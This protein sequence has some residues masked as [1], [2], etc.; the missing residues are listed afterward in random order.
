MSRKIAALLWLLLA[1]PAAA[2]PALWH[3]RGSGGEV[4]LLGSIH[5][6][7]PDVAWRSPAIDAAIKRADVFVF[8]VPENAK[9]IS[10]M[11]E[12]VAARGHLP[13]S[14]TLRDMIHP[15]KRAAFDAALRA[16]SVPE[17]A[18]AHDRPWLA[19]LAL[20]FAQT[21]KAKFDPGKGVDMTLMGEAHKNHKWLRYLE[22][23]DQQFAV[24][25]PDDPELELEE[26]ESGLDD[27]K[28]ISAEI[29]PL[30]DAWSAGDT[31]KLDTL[32]NGDLDEFPAA[33][34][35]LLDDRNA[36]WLPQVQAMLREKR[37]FFITVGAGHL[38]GV[39]GLPALLRK[40][41]YKVEG[42]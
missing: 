1:L 27:L 9:A 32:V 19:G 23:I 8:E 35:A 26:F 39:K 28:D 40:A 4:Y 30:V 11:K 25:A 10:R 12:L 6:L 15:E 34:K 2:D 22:T 36:R 33:R 13:E 42:P 14:Q 41:G 17:D 20:L 3:V 7:P 31:G 29:K 21:A 37:V 18:V 38:T 5:M 24:L 16:S